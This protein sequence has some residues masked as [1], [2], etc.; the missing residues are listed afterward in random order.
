MVYD[1]IKKLQKEENDIHN[2]LNR[3]LKYCFLFQLPICV[4]PDFF[5]MLKPKQCTTTD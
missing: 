3:L 4:K 1:I 2:Y 5:H